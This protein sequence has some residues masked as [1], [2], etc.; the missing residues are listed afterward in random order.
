MRSSLDKRNKTCFSNFYIKIAY[1]FVAV[2]ISLTRKTKAETW[3][4]FLL[5]YWVFFVCLF[6]LKPPGNNFYVCFRYGIVSVT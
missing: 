2:V 5:L 1:S 6:L 3:F 4:W